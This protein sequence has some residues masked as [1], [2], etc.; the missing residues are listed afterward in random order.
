MA[1]ASPA[2]VLNDD[3]QY[4]RDLESLAETNESSYCLAKTSAPISHLLVIDTDILVIEFLFC[5]NKLLSGRSLLAG[6]PIHNSF[7]DS[8]QTSQRWQLVPSVG[9]QECCSMSLL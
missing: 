6:P 1:H 2:C 3:A 7:F 8:E 9:T 4:A 5:N